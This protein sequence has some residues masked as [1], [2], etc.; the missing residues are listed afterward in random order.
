[1]ATPS[2]TADM[3]T[4]GT[5][6]PTPADYY[7]V[8]RGGGLFSETV[9]QRLGAYI[10]A[11]IGPFLAGIIAIVAPAGLGVRDAAMTGMLHAAGVSPGDTVIVVVIARAWATL[12]DVVPA[13]I[14]LLLQ[15]LVPFAW[16]L[17]KYG[18]GLH[19]FC[20]LHLREF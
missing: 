19:R 20:D 5:P 11:W 1:M 7:A 15:R 2:P 13:I 14:V 10:A 17:G 3:T 8:N 12:L 18:I 16:Y 9:S 6:A 4:P